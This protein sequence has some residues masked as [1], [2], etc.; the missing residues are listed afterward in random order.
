MQNVNQTDKHALSF[1]LLL[2]CELWAGD[3]GLREAGE[4]S[5]YRNCADGEDNNSNQRVMQK[6]TPRPTPP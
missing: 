5:Q 2:D 3:F 1:E 4:D 6:K